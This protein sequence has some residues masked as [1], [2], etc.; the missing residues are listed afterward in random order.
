VCA[1]CRFRSATTPS[2]FV[3][4]PCC[5]QQALSTRSGRLALVDIAVEIC[6]NRLPSGKPLHTPSDAPASQREWSGTGAAS[7]RVGAA[8]ATDFDVEA[9]DRSR[10]SVLAS[11]DCCR[12]FS[13][14][15][16]FSPPHSS[17]VINSRWRPLSIAVA[18]RHRR[19]ENLATIGLAAAAA[20][21][22]SE[23]SRNRRRLSSPPFSSVLRRPLPIKPRRVH[24]RHSLRA[25]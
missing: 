2:I 1:R 10:R 14:G 4:K 23:P 3:A 19:V 7:S 22:G 18:I 17:M 21:S 24:E 12:T 16:R 13:T 6:R 9:G 8:T 25:S 5:V 15:R 11:R 20:R